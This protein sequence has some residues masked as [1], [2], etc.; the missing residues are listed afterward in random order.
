VPL[1]Y[2][3]VEDKDVKRATLLGLVPDAPAPMAAY[4]SH[5]PIMARFPE[6]KVDFPSSAYCCTAVG[7]YLCTGKP[8]LLMR[9]Q[10]GVTS[11]A[12]TARQPQIHRLWFC[13]RSIRPK[14]LHQRGRE[15]RTA[16]NGRDSLR[17]TVNALG[18]CRE[19]LPG[20][21]G[22]ASLV[23]QGGLGCSLPL[24]G[25]RVCCEAVSWSP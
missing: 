25:R 19:A 22:P 9:A 10:D 2:I 8:S 1:Y 4:E 11:G 7:R 17:G 3:P 14:P 23:P 21:R 18:T 6:H 24:R 13:L 15:L 16:A 20:C 5:C 12:M